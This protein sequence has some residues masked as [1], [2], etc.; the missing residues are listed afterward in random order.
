MTNTLKQANREWATRPD[1]QRFTSLIELNQHCHAMRD[2]SRQGTISS[3]AIE[4]TAGDDMLNDLRANGMPM[5]NWAFSQ[6]AQ[7]AGGTAGYLSKLPA[8]LAA[9]CLD[10]GMKVNAPPADMGYLIQGDSLA[11]LTGAGYGRIYNAQVTQSLVDRFGDGLKGDWRVPGEFGKAVEVTKANTTL[12]ASDRDMF[13]FLAD[14]GNRI[15]L[16]NRRDGKTG[17]LARGFFVWNS[18]VGSASIGI[19]SFL[20]DYVCANRTVWGVEGF[21]EIRLRHTVSAPDRWMDEVM[22]VI[23]AY[24]QAGVA[25]V[26]AALIAAQNSKLDNAAEWLQSR[27][28]KA[29]AESY[30]NAHLIEENRPIESLWD[31][32][33]AIT[34]AAKRIQH[35]NAR[36]LEER[37]AG[38]VLQLA[39]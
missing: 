39:A 2:I 6:A 36:V 14:E 30:A 37:E 28:G 1:D 23:K 7:A 34:A 11:A 24:S 27:Y 22:P 19:A 18:E 8:V 26:Q 9:Q 20:F 5:T 3:R 25:P 15:E 4:F 12:Y 32:S 38:K 13:V 16:P 10:Y 17:S 33:T 31:V 29:K 21:R 35:T